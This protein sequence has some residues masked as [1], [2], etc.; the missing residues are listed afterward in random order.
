MCLFFLTGLTPTRRSS[1]IRLAL[2]VRSA[3][4]ASPSSYFWYHRLTRSSEA[5]C[6]IAPERRRFGDERVSSAP[7]TPPPHAAAP[8][9][10]DAP[11]VC[12]PTRALP[13]LRI[14]PHDTDTGALMDAHTRAYAQS[15]VGGA[16]ASGLQMGASVPDHFLD[17]LSGSLM[18][19]PVTLMNS[20]VTLERLTLQAW[21]RDGAAPA[22]SCSNLPC[23]VSSW[24]RRAH[25]RLGQWHCLPQRSDRGMSTAKAAA[26]WECVM[27]W[28]S[29]V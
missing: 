22:L 24:T 25:K 10:T 14:P 15:F 12:T 21:L 5:R 11:G 17:P 2:L 6:L 1:V 4:T 28:Y 3:L 20:G 19:E 9:S 27:S 18:L 26:A 8:T 13:P 7:A 23:L 29:P 16:P